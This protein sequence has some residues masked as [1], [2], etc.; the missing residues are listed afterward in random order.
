MVTG[1]PR[2]F[3]RWHNPSGTIY[4]TIVAAST[5]LAAAEGTHDVA[6]IALT[7]VATLLLYWVAHAYAEVLGGAHSDV[8]FWLATRDELAA[9]S[10]M[11][12]ACV[13]PLAALL[14]ATG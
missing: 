12:S 9:E 11:M 3:E 14:L 4:G 6:E 10:S 2:V 5:I 8:P 13:L 1:V 7:V